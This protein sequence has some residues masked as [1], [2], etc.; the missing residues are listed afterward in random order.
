MTL[1]DI[2]RSI[3]AGTVVWE[4][5]PLP[6][7]QRV[8]RL[9]AGDSYNLTRLDISAHTST[10]VDAPLHFVPGGAGVDSLPLDVLVGPAWV[11]DLSGCAEIH[12]A[13]LVSAAI[14]VGVTR[15]L[16]KTGSM[17][18]ETTTVFDPG[19]AALALDGARWLLERG[20][21]LVGIDTISIEGYASVNA[22]SA[23]HHALLEAGVVIIENLELSAVVPG[24][25][26]VTCLPLKL[27][28][29]DGAPARV[30]LESESA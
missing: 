18:E 11:A 2:T 15:L 6:N 24:A 17:P 5:D 4:G 21:R 23:V 13:D 29:A 19:F 25:Y 9:E 3:S 16:L 28:G 1:Y 14:P 27:V 7:L 10:H 30:I 26:R 12:A 20:V 22:S 8:Q